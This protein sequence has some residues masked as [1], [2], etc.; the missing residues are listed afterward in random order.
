[1]RLSESDGTEAVP[2]HFR[3]YLLAFIAVDYFYHRIVKGWAAQISISLRLPQIR[4][5]SENVIKDLLDGEKSMRVLGDSMGCSSLVLAAAICL[6]YAPLELEAQTSPTPAPSQTA[7]TPADANAKAPTLNAGTPQV[8]PV[9]KSPAGAKAAGQTS[10]AKPNAPEPSYLKRIVSVGVAAGDSQTPDANEIVSLL[11]TPTPFTLK[12]RG[13]SSVL[14]YSSKQKLG[15]EE[16]SLLDLL[17]TQIADLAAEQNQIKEIQIAHA[18]ALGDFVKQIQSLNYEEIKVEAVG[19]DRIRIVYGPNVTSSRIQ[20]FIRDLHHLESQPKPDSPV[21]RLFFINASGV[22]GALSGHNP[23]PS[24]PKSAAPAAPSGSSSKPQPAKPTSKPAKASG[25]SPSPSDKTAAT[26]GEATVGCPVGSNAAAKDPPAAACPGSPA[27][28]PDD[29]AGAAQGGPAQ[30]PAQGTNAKAAVS[31]TSLGSDLLVFSDEHPGDDA[32]ITESKRVLAQVDFPRPE[33]I[34]N[35]FSFQSSSTSPDLLYETDQAVRREMGRY[36]DGLQQGIARSWA[37]L[38][39]QMRRGDFFDQTFKDYLTKYYVGDATDVPAGFTDASLNLPANSAE[40]KSTVDFSDHRAKLS[41]DR[42][43]L[44]ICDVEKYCLGYT[45]LFHPLRPSLT[46]MLLAVIA[47]REPWNQIDKAISVMEGAEFLSPLECK[48]NACGM[49]KLKSCQEKACKMP[50]APTCDQMDEEALQAQDFQK[51]LIFPMN[52]FRATAK[53]IFGSDSNKPSLVGPLRAA[54]ANFLFHYKMSEQYPH[55]FSAYDLSQSAQEFNSELNPLVVAF[56]RDLEAALRPLKNAADPRRHSSKGWLGFAAHDVNFVNNGIL[57]VRT[58]SGKET[59]VDTITQSFFDTANPPSIMDVINS[60]GAA[61]SGV[62]KVLKANLTADEA[63]VIIG[64][65]NSVK[66]GQSKVG[67]QFKIDVTPQTL[68]GASAAELEIN[69]TTQESADPTL[70][71]NGKSEADNISRVARHN[72]QTK[73]RLE[74]AK[75][76][77]ISSFAAMLQRSRKNFPLILPFV[78]IPYIGA[79]V[80]VPLPGAKEYHASTAIMSAVVV[81]TAA[82]LANGVTFTADRIALPN[83]NSANGECPLNPAGV[84]NCTLRKALSMNDLGVYSI[85]SY[86]HA[87]VSCLGSGSSY[88]SA[89]DQTAWRVC[90]ELRLNAVPPDER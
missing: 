23:A 84:L 82:D 69:L 76:F 44:G 18:S 49:P 58:I 88:P 32:A 45:T 12:A 85:R 15:R 17:E 46:D 56:N 74:S 41:G 31:V 10:G 13:Q 68:S 16:E 89:N 90:G 75:L 59:T 28:P 72:T 80:S 26:S 57:T 43:R 36:N 86:H 70:Y 20:E 2:C 63:A 5:D 47:S 67:R 83:S 65:L 81:P 27:T 55:E 38:A 30:P 66:E 42:N 87:M 40:N 37:Y 71:S 14:I 9:V 8:K 22:A 79:V 35:T 34:I 54:V 33:V 78:E 21:A 73:V 48:R 52:C 29:P 51:G 4:T 6:F 24:T 3:S 64:A 77:E 7:T 11:G 50:D 39:E 25:A 62:P 53:E 1:M 61:E 19:A 60:I